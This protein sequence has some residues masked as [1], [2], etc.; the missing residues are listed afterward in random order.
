MTSPD[1]RP[2][3]GRAVYLFLAII[4]LTWAANWPL[5]KL[6]LSDA[7]PLVFVLVRLLGTVAL[8]APTLA[9]MRVPLLPIPGERLGLFW[10]GQLQV[11]GF[12]LFAIV[13]LA[14]EAPGRAIVLAYTFSLWAIPI[15]VLLGV[16][17]L[18]RFHLIGAAIGF[19][20]LV[21][22]MNPGLVDWSSPRALFGNLFLLLSAIAWAL[23]SCL[24]RRRM[25]RTGFW[26]QTFWQLAVSAPV[27]L[28][29]ALP[30]LSG[31]PIH[32]SARLLAIL[33]YNWVVTTALGYFLWAKVLTAMPAATAGQVLALTPVGGF[34]LSILIFGGT[35]T[36]DVIASIALIV[37]GIILTLRA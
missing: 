24:Y 17:R 30:Q 33:A 6:A 36:P 18:G 8:L 7:P 19:A 23:G 3:P 1:E 10:V 9:A 32:W 12:L 21:L 26:T 28:A 15:G 13:G 22:F 5:M 20:G 27:V 2:G 37:A 11:A 31:E 16:E 4:V 35:V 29:F 34:L 14:I 25:W